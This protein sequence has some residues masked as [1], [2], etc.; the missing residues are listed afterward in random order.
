MGLS[1]SFNDKDKPNGPQGTV[2]AITRLKTGDGDV[3][4]LRIRPPKDFTYKAGQ[5]VGVGF[6]K[7]SPRL[8]SISNA[9]G[10]GE[11]SVHIKRT[12][13]EV[14]IYLE[15]VL[16]VGDEVGLSPAAGTSTFDPTD[17]RPILIIAGGLGFTPMKAIAEAAV[18][19]DQNAT[20][21]FFWGTNKADEKYMRAYFEDMAEQ[22]DNFTFH[23]INGTPVGEKAAQHFPDLSG[24]RIFMAGPPAMIDATLPLLRARGADDGA[25]SYDTPPPRKNLTP[26]ND[27]R[28]A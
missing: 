4:L 27:N 26:D 1:A 14:G 9:P 22:Y 15:A 16:R 6:G 12:K 13:G 18:R 11:L 21:H 17:R 24:F 20:V 7:L 8:Y 23:D 28:P 5:Y 2:T 3:Y 19:H 25:I 10:E